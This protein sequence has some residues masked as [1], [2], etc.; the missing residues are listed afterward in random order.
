MTTEPDDRAALGIDVLKSFAYVIPLEKF[1]YR[2]ADRWAVYEPVGVGGLTAHLYEQGLDEKSVRDLL[3]QKP[4]VKTYG[5]TME[6]GAGPVYIDS[7]DR[8]YLNTWVAPTLV[9]EPHP[10]PRIERLLSWLTQGDSAGAEWICHWLALKV[11]NPAIVPMVAV[12]LATKPGG[13]KGTLAM[14]L[15]QM[16]GPENCAVIESGA[17]ESRF[18]SRWAGKLFV[19]ADEVI[20]SESGKDVSNRLKVLITGDDIELEGKGTNQIAIRNRAAWMFASNDDVAPV[21]VEQS[22]RR[23]TIFG[24]FNELPTDYREMLNRCFEADRRTP[25]ASFSKEIAGFY[26][27]LLALQVDRRLVEY[28]Y[29][30]DARQELIEASLPGHKQFFGHVD[31]VGID[32]L[33]ERVVTHGDWSLTKTRPEWDLGAQGVAAQMVYECYRIY[34]GDVGCKPLRANRFGVAVR[35]HGW[36]TP[37]L[38]DARRIYYTVRRVGGA[39][40]PGPKGFP[41]TEAAA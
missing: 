41:Q 10:Y 21:L 3:E 17:L 27:D 34:C 11:Q 13:G 30:N 25:T 19:L 40:T 39:V 32:A 35:K 7:E 23:Y 6:P 2:K 37:R 26:H 33:L 1:V 12:V 29:D 24:N 9:P 18:N 22:D 15:R 38:G 4:Y 5:W 16:L 20:T 36:P 8:A 28:P 14:I 31:V